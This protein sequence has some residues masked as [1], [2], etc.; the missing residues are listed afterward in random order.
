MNANSCALWAKFPE[1]YVRETIIPKLETLGLKVTKF[2]TPK[3]RNF[4]LFNVEHVL[5]M[6][7]FCAHVEFDSFEKQAKRYNKTVTVISR[8]QSAWP[9]ELKYV[10]AKV[11][12][13][14]SQSIEPAS[15]QMKQKR[16]ESLIVTSVNSDSKLYRLIPDEKIPDFEKIYIDL[17]PINLEL[18]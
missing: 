13:S 18:V 5:F 1:G 11:Q 15:E 10:L 8:K 4:D 17:K 9:Q 14:K 3:N 7:E 6:N 16:K 2:F 12:K